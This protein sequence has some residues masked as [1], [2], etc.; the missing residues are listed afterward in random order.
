MSGIIDLRQREVKQ[1]L[2]KQQIQACLENAT[3][4]ELQFAVEFPELQAYLSGPPRPAAVL[5]PFLMK[6]D[7]WHLL[8]TRRTTALQE[9]SGQV[10][11]PGGRMD[12]LDENPY[13]TA[14]REAQEEISLAPKD[15]QVLGRLNDYLT[16]TNYL[17][18][19]VVGI[20]PWPYPLR[21][22]PHEVSRV[23][24]IP[25]NW[26]ANPQHHEIRQRTIPGREKPIPVVYFQSYEG[27]ILWGATARFTLDLLKVLNLNG[28][29]NEQ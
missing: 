16:I 21:A 28:A 5:I 20:M 25:L 27:E 11:F 3:W 19:P 26:L 14:L 7:G 4:Q 8:F 9:H 17:V 10:A 15:V 18:T 2:E 6:D 1:L 22:S 23:F 24:T 12:P 29:V 13:A